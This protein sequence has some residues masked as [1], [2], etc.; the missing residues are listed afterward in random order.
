MN[1]WVRLRGSWRLRRGYC[2]LCNSSPPRP[3]CPVCEGR[4]DYGP[5]IGGLRRNVLIYR[6]HNYLDEVKHRHPRRR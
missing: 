2:P 4:H 6:W 1:L 3:S 5:L